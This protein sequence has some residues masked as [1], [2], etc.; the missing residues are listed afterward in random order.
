TVPACTIFCAFIQTLSSAICFSG[1]TLSMWVFLGKAIALWWGYLYE[2][3]SLIFIDN[4]SDF[5]ADFAI[6]IKDKLPNPDV[7]F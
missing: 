7:C 5:G 1:S 3:S 6:A 2:V 4:L